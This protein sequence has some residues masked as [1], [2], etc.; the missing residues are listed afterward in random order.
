MPQDRLDVGLKAGAAYGQHF[1]VW[2]AQRCAPTDV[3]AMQTLAP[4][5]LCVNF[6]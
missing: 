6:F 3:T 4:Q 5:R 2:S 1:G